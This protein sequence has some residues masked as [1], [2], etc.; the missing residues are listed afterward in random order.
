MQEHREIVSGVCKNLGVDA[1]LMC[2][3]FTVES[4]WDPYAVRFEPI[5]NISRHPAEKYAKKLGITAE[6]ERTL[7][8]CSWG[9]GQVMGTT[10]R[11]LGFDGPLPMLCD[12]Y[13]GAT[14]AVR[15][16][17]RLQKR[18]PDR[19]DQIAAYNAGTATFDTYKRYV[20]QAYVDKVLKHL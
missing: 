9:L 3:I 8:R 4:A 15:Y 20:N 14:W 6:T 5:F 10:A 1:D 12:P 7:A 16:M 19:N 13:T 18:F 17:L 2:A 11:H